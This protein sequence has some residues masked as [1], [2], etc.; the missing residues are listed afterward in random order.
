MRNKLLE[1][2][3]SLLE[4]EVIDTDTQVNETR[5]H[6]GVKVYLLGKLVGY[7]REIDIRAV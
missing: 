4:R 2:A 7:S 1:L 6:R 3:I 5:K